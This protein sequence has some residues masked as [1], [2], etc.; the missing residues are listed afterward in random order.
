M[1]IFSP[2]KGVVAIALAMILSAGT[3]AVT[4]YASAQHADQPDGN[5]LLAQ[6]LGPDPPVDACSDEEDNDNDGDTD[7]D[8]ANC[9]DSSPHSELW[10]N[11]DSND[12][13]AMTAE[14]VLAMAIQ[15][16]QPACPNTSANS[17]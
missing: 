6:D 7:E 4:G 15:R 14:V 3:F 16:Q 9:C 10:G 2:K 8:D 17:V 12:G 13:G 5:Q 1:H 11:C